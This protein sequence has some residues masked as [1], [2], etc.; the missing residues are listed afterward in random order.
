MDVY[1]KIIYMFS[2]KWDLIW[3]CS[4]NFTKIL[5]FALNI[6]EIVYTAF[7]SVSIDG[8]F[9]NIYIYIQNSHHLIYIFDIYMF[10]ILMGFDFMLFH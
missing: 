3:F 2:F 8:Y 7:L 5:F 9:E 6:H 4:I 10:L 1:F